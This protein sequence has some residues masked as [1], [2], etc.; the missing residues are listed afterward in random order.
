MVGKFGN[1]GRFRELDTGEYIS[2]LDGSKG[3]ET[4]EKMRR[5]DSTI[6]VILDAIELS[7]RR[8]SWTI[9]PSAEDPKSK[10]IAEIMNEDLFKK[11]ETTWDDTIRHALLMLPFGFSLLEK[12]W[13]VRDNRVVPKDLPARLPYSIVGWDLEYSGKNKGPIQQTIDGQEIILP[14]NKI[15]CFTNRR[16]GANY[17]GIS[18]LRRSYKNWF[19]KENLEKINGIKHERHGVGIPTMKHPEIVSPGTEDHDNM[20]SALEDISANEKGYMTVPEGYEFN[21]VGAGGPN[22]GTDILSSIKYYDEKIAQSALAM[23]LYLGTTESG[24][25]SLGDSF[26]DLFTKSLEAY[27]DYLCQVFNRYFII[28]WVNY[29]WSVKEY[30]ELTY[31]GIQSLNIDKIIQLLG[32]GGITATIET[33]NAI[34]R[35]TNLPER[36]EPSIEKQDPTEPVDN[37]DEEIPANP[38]VEYSDLVYEEKIPELS[39]IEKFLDQTTDSLTEQLIIIRD[40][41][42]KSII[43][44]IMSGKTVPQIVVPE[45]KDMFETLKRAYVSSFKEGQ[46]EVKKEVS[47]QTNLKEYADPVPGKDLDQYSI[48]ELSLLTEGASDKL[49]T[50]IIKRALELKKQGLSGNELKK[51]LEDYVSGIS[52][53]TGISVAT[54][55]DAAG[56]AVN[57]GWGNGRTSEQEKYYDEIDYMYRSAILDKYTCEVCREK[58]GKRHNPGDPEYMAPDPQCFGGDGKCRCINITVFKEESRKSGGNT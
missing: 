51:A 36:E 22:G 37:P 21:I 14:W 20:I 7:I 30:P 54:W 25:R 55:K 6:G 45:K 29:N 10:E 44:Q 42:S 9:E 23:F 34:R 5:S 28:E 17:E 24:S 58:N 32:A 8:A 31:T 48:E 1:E 15:L 11:M 12:V 57:G 3:R 50:L 4:F 47:K 26:I 13:T 52:G 43:E 38:S 53:E 49:K 16:E 35:E 19:L 41:Q 40:K 56:K 33:E 39:T 18:I 46:R 27:A 2:S